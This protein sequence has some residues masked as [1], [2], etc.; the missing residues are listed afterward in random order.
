MY[1]AI[2]VL[3]LIKLQNKARFYTYVFN[4]YNLMNNNA[5]QK[6]ILD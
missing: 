3:A 2:Y 6:N 5:Q 4:E 1:L